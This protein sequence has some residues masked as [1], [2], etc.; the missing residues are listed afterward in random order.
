MA[1]FYP[2]YL[3]L[4]NKAC[5]VI[6]GD[7]EGLRKTLGLLDAEAY[8]TLIAEEAVDGLVELAEKG[9]ITWHRRGYHQGDLKDVFLAIAT[10]E[11]RTQFEVIHEEGNERGV[12]LNCMDDPPHCIWIAPSIIRRGDVTIAMSTGG[13][14]PAYARWLRA[15][16]EQVLP[17]EFIAL[18][19][20]MMELREEF[21]QGERHIADFE[22]WQISPD[23]EVMRL[24]GKGKRDEAKAVFREWLLTP[25]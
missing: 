16:L 13:R 20:L 4:R 1:W 2:I 8:V 22:R 21:R 15:N 19:E 17:E 14:S 24:L 9:R 11:V 12:L 23:H 10:P 7:R 5:L 3:D 25:A 6:G 18:G